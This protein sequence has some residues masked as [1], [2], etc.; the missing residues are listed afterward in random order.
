MPMGRVLH[1]WLLDLASGR[2]TD[3]F[4]GTALELPRDSEGP[5]GFDV[6]PGGACVA[7]VNDPAATPLLGNR[8]K[9]HG[10]PAR[11]LWFPD[12]NHWVL[13][14]RNPKLWCGEFPEWIEAHAPAARLRRQP[15]RHPQS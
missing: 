14:A 6:S 8:F 1:L 5:A 13:K 9:A 15:P 10:V 11:L 12:E 4:E 3:L 7:F 2:A